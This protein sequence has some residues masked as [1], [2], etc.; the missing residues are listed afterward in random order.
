MLEHVMPYVCLSMSCVQGMLQQGVI[1]F[2]AHVQ[3]H[4][5]TLTE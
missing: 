2:E 5:K 3:P 1:A 4:K